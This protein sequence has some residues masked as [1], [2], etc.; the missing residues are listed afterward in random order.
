MQHR[1]SPN[2]PHSVYMFFFHFHSFVIFVNT[3]KKRPAKER[4]S[5]SFP[6][7]RPPHQTSGP[8]TQPVWVYVLNALPRAPRTHIVKGKSLH[9]HMRPAHH[10]R[11][12]R[13]KSRR[14]SP[15]PHTLT[16]GGDDRFVT[17]S[18]TLVVVCNETRAA[19]CV[20]NASVEN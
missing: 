13:T 3:I 2:A 19:R 16:A 14:K 10:T 12:P 8:L 5:A 4:K 6:H 18:R 7:P 15:P 9:T 1:N 20:E 11:V 17:R